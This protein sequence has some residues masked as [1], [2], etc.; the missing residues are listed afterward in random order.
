M[1]KHILFLGACYF[2][3]IG[4]VKMVYAIVLKMK[5]NK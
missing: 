3:T 1:M 4:A 2:L 5:E